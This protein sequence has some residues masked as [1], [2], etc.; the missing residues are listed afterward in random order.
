[1]W[2]YESPKNKKQISYIKD[3]EEKSLK[4]TYKGMPLPT[5]LKKMMSVWQD[6]KDAGAE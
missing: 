6:L 2:H 1:M 5:Y 3:N 4:C